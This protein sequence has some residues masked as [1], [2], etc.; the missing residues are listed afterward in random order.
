MVCA[1]LERWFLP[2][3]LRT[4]APKQHRRRNSGSR[5][6]KGGGFPRFG[7]FLRSLASSQVVKR[8]LKAKEQST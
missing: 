3:L 5:A 2:E 7:P 1:V 4:A 8:P 6:F